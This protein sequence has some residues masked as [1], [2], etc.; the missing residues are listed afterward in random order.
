MN[1]RKY[2]LKVLNGTKPVKLVFEEVSKK[3]SELND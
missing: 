3:Q 1:G 2:G